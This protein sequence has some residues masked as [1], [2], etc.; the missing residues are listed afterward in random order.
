LDAAV[1][2]GY[3]IFGVT[4]HAPRGEERFLYPS[5]LEKGYTV[6]RLEAEFQAYSEAI[7]SLRRR[8][9]GR[10]TLLKGFEA[11]VV[12]HDRYVERMGDYRDRFGFEYMVGSVH[13]IGDVQIDGSAELFSKA[14]Q[15]A[16]G[17]EAL[18][19]RYYE[20]VAEMIRCLRPEV[21][22]HFD[23]VR[24]NAPPGAAL[25]SPA[26]RKAARSA[27]EIARD[28][29]SILD[30]NTAGYRKG[31]GGPYPDSWIVRM[32]SE[33]GLGFCFGDDSHSVSDVGAGL[34]EARDYLLQHGVDR[35]RVLNRVAGGLRKE[36]RPLLS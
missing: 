21:V 10:M 4:E 11:E 25:D 27:L 15:L 22:A 8:F 14:V 29:D 31:L 18:A 30:L 5:E 17:L 28:C 1:R 9:G 3:S 7:D 13:H 23:L 33:M 35:I 6:E 26:I 20:T 19:V 36:W 2:V 12:P 32:A 24:R 16:G 34:E